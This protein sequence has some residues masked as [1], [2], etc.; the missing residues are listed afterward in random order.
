MTSFVGEVEDEIEAASA[1]ELKI[2]EWHP[3]T[4]KKHPRGWSWLTAPGLLG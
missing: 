3:S 1:L 2:N 4:N